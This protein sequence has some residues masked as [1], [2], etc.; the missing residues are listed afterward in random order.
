MQQI[1]DL[2][3]LVYVLVL[4][5]LLL[6]VGKWKRLHTYHNNDHRN[7]HDN[8]YLPTTTT[9]TKTKIATTLPTT[10]TTKTTTTTT[11]VPTCNSIICKY[12][13]PGHWSPSNGVAL[14]GPANS[15]VD[16]SQTHVVI[17]SCLIPLTATVLF[18]LLCALIG[19]PLTALSDFTND[20]I[21]AIKA[22]AFSMY[23]NLTV[24]YCDFKS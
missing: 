23:R 10:T 16:C 4:C 8:H 3:V 18:V 19:I 9:S 12:Q 6:T 1:T 2:A 24:M 15:G 11:P 20:Y 14:T 13:S 22:G 17:T 5:C 21:T 7:D